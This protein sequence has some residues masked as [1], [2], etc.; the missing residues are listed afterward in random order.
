MVLILCIDARYIQQK[1]VLLRHMLRL[2]LQ[3][4]RIFFDNFALSFEFEGEGLPH[5]SALNILHQGMRTSMV[6]L[7]FTNL[8]WGIGAY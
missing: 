5:A 8:G 7:S 1:V 4:T 6:M 3:K 2:F